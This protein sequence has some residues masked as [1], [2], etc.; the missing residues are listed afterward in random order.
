MTQIITRAIKNQIQFNY[1]Y[2]QYLQKSYTTAA[3]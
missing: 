1:S 3:N 2:P